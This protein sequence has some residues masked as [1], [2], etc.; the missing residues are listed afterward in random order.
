MLFVLI[1]MIYS[2]LILF[3]ITYC[4]SIPAN[5]AKKV[6]STAIQ[7]CIFMLVSTLQIGNPSKDNV[8]P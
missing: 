2:Y 1:L 4:K 8:A 3:A 7:P 6:G 5:R